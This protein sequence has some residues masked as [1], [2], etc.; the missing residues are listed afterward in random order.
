[1]WLVEAAADVGGK[2]VEKGGGGFRWWWEVAVVVVVMGEV[3]GGKVGRWKMGF[4]AE[5]VGMAIGICYLKLG[6]YGLGNPLNFYSQGRSPF[7]HLYIQ[8]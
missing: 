7:I 8:Y 1:V 4:L 3:E 2:D 5:R 6:D